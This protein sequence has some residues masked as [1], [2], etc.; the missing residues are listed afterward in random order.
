MPCRFLR[1]YGVPQ[2]GTLGAL[3]PMMWICFVKEVVARY[4]NSCLLC[5]LRC[6]CF[7]CA[8]AMARYVLFG[9]ALLALC[10]LA[11]A[12]FWPAGIKGAE[13]LEELSAG[14]SQASI[15]AAKSY[16]SSKYK[17]V[18]AGGSRGQLSSSTTYFSFFITADC[19]GQLPART[20]AA[21][22]RLSDSSCDHHPVTHLLP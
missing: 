16:G 9:L 4:R 17:C 13:Q 20:Q 22:G 21:A 6:C 14:P 8:G 11:A 12:E 10:A 5:L 1:P 3:M 2:Q 7:A 18:A 19:C 15:A